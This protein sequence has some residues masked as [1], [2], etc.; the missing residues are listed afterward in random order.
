MSRAVPLPGTVLEDWAAAHGALKTRDLRALDGFLESVLEYP[1][2]SGQAMDRFIEQTYADYRAASAAAKSPS[3]NNVLCETP[4]R[5][6][7]LP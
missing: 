7:V 4:A 3:L 6:M 1:E 2:L 5:D